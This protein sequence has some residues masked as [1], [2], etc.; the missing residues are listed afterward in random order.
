MAEEQEKLICPIYSH[1]VMNSTNAIKNSIAV[2][3]ITNKE[4]FED[5]IGDLLLCHQGH[6]AWWVE[7]SPNGKVPGACA[8]RKIAECMPE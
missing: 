3:S 1:A 5:K 6:C 2:L 7:G 8:I 4:E